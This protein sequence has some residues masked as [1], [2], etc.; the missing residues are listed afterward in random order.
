MARINLLPWREERRKQRQRQ[1]L[2]T[3]GG[4][5]VLMVAVVGFAHTHISGLIEHQHGRNEFLNSE[6]RA[7]DKKIAEIR[8]LDETKRKLLARMEVI[9]QLQSSRPQIVHLFDQLARTV[10]EGVYL[11]S[12]VHQGDVLTIEGV[13]QSNARVSAYMHKLDDSGWLEKAKLQ[14]IETREKQD[15]DSRERLSRFTLR[16]R[17]I[18]K[19]GEDTVQTS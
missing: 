14:V 16:V 19:P 11:S 18:T 10:P 4:A 3:L 9:Q 1:F 8:E 17:Q 5:A 13:A 12:I 6:I 2:T 15:S 7:L